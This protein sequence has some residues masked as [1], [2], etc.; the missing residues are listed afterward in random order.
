MRQ[1][2]RSLDGT[3]FPIRS[4]P[5]HWPE[6]SPRSKHGPPS[7]SQET[8]VSR[9]VLTTVLLAVL[10]MASLASVSVAKFT[11]SDCSNRRSPVCC[12]YKRADGKR[13]RKFVRNKC[14]CKVCRD[15]RV[16]ALGFCSSSRF[17]HLGTDDVA[18]SADQ[19]VMSPVEADV[20]GTM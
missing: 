12:A 15:G 7:A 1:P 19:D 17:S 5:I 13:V 16:R 11:C 10:C 9:T 14:R 3:S 2:L 18:N 6:Q 4:P 20:A 8:M